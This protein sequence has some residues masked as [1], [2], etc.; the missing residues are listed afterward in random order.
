MYPRVRAVLERVDDYCEQAEEQF[1]RLGNGLRRGR[2][3]LEWVRA[4]MEAIYRITEGWGPAFDLVWPIIAA[5][6]ERYI[7]RRNRGR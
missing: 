5:A 1:P 4:R 6:I 3:K 7:A 2:E